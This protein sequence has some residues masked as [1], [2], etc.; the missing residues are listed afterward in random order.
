[1]FLGEPDAG[2]LHVRFDEGGG[3]V[4]ISSIASSSTLLLKEVG[5]HA[6]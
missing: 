3:A 4:W 6:A 5:V 1:M 2:D